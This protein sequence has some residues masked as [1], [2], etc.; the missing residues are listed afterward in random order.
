MLIMILF[1]VLKL[2]MFLSITDKKGYIKKPKG[3]KIGQAALKQS[4]KNEKEIEGDFNKVLKGGRKLHQ[5]QYFKLN[6]S[7]MITAIPN[8]N[9]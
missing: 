2:S 9:Y 6:P 5:L 4:S 3:G 8:S 1:N 7:T